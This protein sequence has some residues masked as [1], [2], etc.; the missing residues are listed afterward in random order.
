MYFSG[1]LAHARVVEHL[2]VNNVHRLFTFAFPKEVYGYLDYCDARQRKADI[3][4]DS[5][6]F[7][8][9]SLGKP[10]RLQELID[11]DHK[12]IAKYPHHNFVFIAL[13]VIP[14]ER[15]R[16]ATQVEIDAAVKQSY[17][18]FLVMRDALRPATVLP[19]FHSG[20]H[21]ELRD[22]YLQLTDYVCLS[23]NQNMTE[24][25]RFRWAQDAIVPGY[26]FH[27]LATTGNKM[28][29]YIDWYSV[30]SSSCLMV[31]A[32]GSIL[33]PVRNKLIPLSVSAQ[34]PARKV[35]DQHIT[36]LY[37]ADWVVPLIRAAGYDE[38]E[39]AVSYAARVCWNIDQWCNPPWKKAPAKLLGLF[40]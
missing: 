35:Q 4:L 20:E 39:L 27:G 1:S 33:F 29:T 23:P 21:K 3:M 2:T 30:D 34:S 36:N 40:D 6:A 28:L 8:A 7:T 5:G 12:L 31:A 22:R 13:D 19:V 15:G 37:E 14:G 25:Q 26:K 32:L 24:Q 17:D 16:M 10:V 9:W 18:N 38:Q 11:Y